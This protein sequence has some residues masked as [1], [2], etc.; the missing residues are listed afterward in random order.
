MGFHLAPAGTIEAGIDGIIETR[1]PATGVGL[2]PQPC[3]SAARWLRCAPPSGALLER[4]VNASDKLDH[5]PDA[6]AG[7][8]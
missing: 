8:R 6:G 5:G 2:A 4:I 1:D 3:G 7:R